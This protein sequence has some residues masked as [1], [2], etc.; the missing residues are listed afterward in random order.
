MNYHLLLTTLIGGMVLLWSYYAVFS[1]EQQS[2]L[3]SRFWVG[4]PKPLIR[5]I[6]AV[7]LVSLVGFIIAFFAPSGLIAG[8]KVPN[9]AYLTC[10]FFAGSV[11][12]AFL[13]KSALE[14]G[15]PVSILLTIMSLT[16]VAVANIT[17]LLAS[18]KARNHTASIGLLLLALTVVLS[19]GVLW[20]I[21][22]ARAAA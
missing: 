3:N 21:M 4:I 2:Y 6:V 9:A 15:G 22:F 11:A 16:M 13:A 14:G 19:D 5:A 1:L 8:R 10:L 18:I 17:L 12:W 7:Q 20:N